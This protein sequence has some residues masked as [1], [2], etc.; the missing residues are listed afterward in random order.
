MSLLNKE[1]KSKPRSRLSAL[2]PVESAQPLTPCI[3]NACYDTLSTSIDNAEDNNIIAVYCPHYKVLMEV[4]LMEGDP[5]GVVLTGPIL[6]NDAIAYINES[7][8][9]PDQTPTPIS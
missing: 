9:S 8:A 1:T 4:T 6:E 7:S 2:M 5:I 3:C